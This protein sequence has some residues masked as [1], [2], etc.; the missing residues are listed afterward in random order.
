MVGVLSALEDPVDALRAAVLSKMGERGQIRGGI[1]DGP[2][3]QLFLPYL[4]H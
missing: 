3:V 2:V 4:T 1:I